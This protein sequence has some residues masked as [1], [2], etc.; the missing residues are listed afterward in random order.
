MPPER[1]GH[2]TL[3]AAV[4]DDNV[5]APGTKGLAAADSGRPAV[6]WARG[7]VETPATT[8]AAESGVGA[9]GPAGETGDVTERGPTGDIT[10]GGGLSPTGE[11]PEVN[12]DG[13]TGRVSAGGIALESSRARR[14][15]R[16]V[17]I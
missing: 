4:G 5:A 14:V 3:P 17:I 1:G 13:A 10:A 8:A 15:A 12:D 11:T 7:P 16:A 2:A 6:R 9:A